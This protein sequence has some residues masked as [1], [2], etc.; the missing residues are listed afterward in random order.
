MISQLLIDSKSRLFVQQ[1]VRNGS[2][3]F[4]GFS[5]DIN[6]T[7]LCRKSSTLMKLFTPQ[8]RAGKAGQTQTESVNIFCFHI[9]QILNAFKKSILLYCPSHVYPSMPVISLLTH[10]P[11][12]RLCRGFFYL[13]IAISCQTSTDGVYKLVIGLCCTTL[14]G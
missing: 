12:P 10:F 3:I 6:S 5:L 2:R 13:K 9:T 14:C 11:L 1:C 7:K 8:A 4:R